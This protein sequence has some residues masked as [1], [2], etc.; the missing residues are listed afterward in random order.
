MLKYCALS[1]SCPF[2]AVCLSE[3]LVDVLLRIVGIEPSCCQA[4]HVAIF[5]GAYGASLSMT[6]T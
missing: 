1:D 2:D 4:S 3:Y 6:G 5:L